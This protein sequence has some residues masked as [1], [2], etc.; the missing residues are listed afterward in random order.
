ML[1]MLKPPVD[2]TPTYYTDFALN[3]PDPSDWKEIQQI[4]KQ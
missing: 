4:T 2:T 1:M 3:A